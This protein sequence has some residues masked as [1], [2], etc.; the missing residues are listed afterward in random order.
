M[1]HQREFIYVL[2]CSISGLCQI[3]SSPLQWEGQ[4]GAGLTT[5]GYVAGHSSNATE[6]SVGR[7]HAGGVYFWLGFGFPYRLTIRID[8]LLVLILS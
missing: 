7:S 1:E 2:A 6:H 4:G 8:A 3:G 5:A